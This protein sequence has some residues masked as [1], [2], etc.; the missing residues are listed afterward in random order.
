MS[1][2]LEAYKQDFKAAQLAL[3]AEDFEL[4]NIF[5][6]RMMANASIFKDSK[7]ALPGFFLKDIAL[8]LLPLKERRSP[9][10][11]VTAKNVTESY[12]KE[13]FENTKEGKFSLK[14]LWES[15]LDFYNRVRVTLLNEQEK[16]SYIK[17]MPNFTHI[18]YQRLLEFLD[19]NKELL[20]H[21][22]CRLLAGIINEMDRISRAHGIELADLLIRSLIVSLNR[23]YEYVSTT[24][25]SQEEFTKRVK[26]EILHYIPRILQVTEIIEKSVEEANSLLWE[27]IDQWR[28]YFMKY[29]EIPRP[30]LVKEREELPEEVRKR[31][32][33]GVAKA[34]EKEV[35]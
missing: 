27:L 22:R 2:D 4:M 32:I 8:A 26:E 14:H 11:L 16:E 15:Y 20:H 35:K 31:L 30:I 34:L 24:S 3:E 17:E 25:D 18:A 5:A 7:F 9:T 1:Y 21:K 12:V 23:C 28:E 6:N 13:L 10:P 33:E 19:A 29:M